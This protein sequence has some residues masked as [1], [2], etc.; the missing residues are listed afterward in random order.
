M[1]PVRD[2]GRTISAGAVADL[3]GRDR[4][5]LRAMTPDEAGSDVRTVRE[6]LGVDHAWMSRYR[7][8]L[9]D[10]G[11]VRTD[12]RGRLAYALP[13]LRDYLLTLDA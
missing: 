4:D 6:R 10:A 2:A 12:G 9:L 7:Q 3:S 8:Q 13:Y 11:M 1:R 5:V